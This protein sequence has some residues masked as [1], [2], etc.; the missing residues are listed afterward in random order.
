MKTNILSLM[1]LF[2]IQS[3]EDLNQ[4][5]ETDNSCWTNPH[6]AE[7]RREKGPKRQ[8]RQQKPKKESMT[9]S[10]PK[11]SQTGTRLNKRFIYFLKKCNLLNSRK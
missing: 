8:K 2:K 1:K 10:I 6:I 3:K 7:T 11:Y 4:K 9:Q 5:E